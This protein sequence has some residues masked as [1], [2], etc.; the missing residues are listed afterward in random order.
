MFTNTIKILDGLAYLLQ[1]GYRSTAIKLADVS[2]S[3]DDQIS[4][5]IIQS[6]I[7][8]YITL[9][10]L[11]TLNRR[12]M[13]EKILSNST[14]KSLMENVPEISDIFEHFLNGRYLEFQ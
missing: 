3:N 5:I 4:Q 12:E 6:D 7:A 9:T 14:F 10:A 11:T 8:F 13:R 2:V 1:D